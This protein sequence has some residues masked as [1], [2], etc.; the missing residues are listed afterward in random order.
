MF[1]IA[2]DNKT[3]MGIVSENDARNND[4]INV[5]KKGGNYGFLG[6]HCVLINPISTANR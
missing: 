5:L 6:Q 3:R 1:G 2:F 4:E